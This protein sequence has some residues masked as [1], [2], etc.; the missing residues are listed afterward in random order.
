MS[1]VFAG[2]GFETFNSPRRYSSS[3]VRPY[4]ED[5]ASNSSGL[6]KFNGY[7]N[8]YTFYRFSFSVNPNFLD[9]ESDR[10]A[11]QVTTGPG[12]S[13]WNFLECVDGNFTCRR[14]FDTTSAYLSSV[15]PIPEPETYALMLAGL[16][17][18]GAAAKRRKAK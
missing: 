2:G 10:L 11:L 12:G 18:V 15:S 9:V 8:R 5:S 1:N 13:Q 3:D 17:L 4:D 14:S 7:E 16:A 6:L